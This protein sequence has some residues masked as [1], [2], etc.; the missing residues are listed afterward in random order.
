VIYTQFELNDM[1]DHVS[2]PFILLFLQEKGGRFQVDLK[3]TWLQNRKAFAENAATISRGF[4][5]DAPI[6]FNA[7]LAKYCHRSGEL[8]DAIRA[9]KAGMDE[10]QLQTFFVLLSR[11]VPGEIPKKYGAEWR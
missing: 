11:V 10:G 4:F 2:A 1:T 5:S 3:Y 7:I 9:A 6:L 8:A